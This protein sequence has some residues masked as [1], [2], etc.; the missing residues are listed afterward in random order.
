MRSA[1]RCDR[2][3]VPRWSLWLVALICFAPLAALWLLGVLYSLFWVSVFSVQLAVPERFPD[4]LSVPIWSFIAPIAYVLGG[5]IGLVG[6]VRVLSLP[7]RE[8]PKS[9]RFFTLGMVAVGLGA[10][11]LF[12]LP[13]LFDAITGFENGVPV[14]PMAVYLVLPFTGAAWML[15]KSRKFLFADRRC[16]RSDR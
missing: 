12:N 6:L 7:R 14:V 16:D 3:D 4:D 15:C 13:L 10:V 9:H 11:A 2:H 1:T 5:F 8:P